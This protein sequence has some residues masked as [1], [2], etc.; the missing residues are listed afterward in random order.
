MYGSWEDDSTLAVRL[1]HATAAAPGV[2]VGIKPGVLWP[3]VWAHPGTC[4]GARSKC[5]SADTIAA[6]HVDG[7]FPCDVRETEQ[8]ELCVV[9]TALIQAPEKI[10]SCPGTQLTP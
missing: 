4:H 2:R 7:D 6:I 3:R 8:R 9:P 1:T 5:T 10:S